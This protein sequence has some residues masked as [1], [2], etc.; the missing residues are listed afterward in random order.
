[1]PNFQII[2]TKPKYASGNYQFS[3]F[4]D[5]YWWLITIK[6]LA[7]GTPGRWLYHLAKNGRSGTSSARADIAIQSDWHDY[8]LARDAA[9]KTT[10]LKT[11]WDDVY[12]ASNDAALSFVRHLDSTLDS[13][14]I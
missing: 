14:N 3:K 10:L 7:K 6:G 1:M 11:H 5:L 13:S 12:N 8:F 4:E 2:C 9:K